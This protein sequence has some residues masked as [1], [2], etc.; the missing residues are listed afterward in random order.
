MS[1]PAAEAA[2]AARYLAREVQLGPF[3]EGFARLIVILLSRLHGRRELAQ[4]KLPP[5]DLDLNMT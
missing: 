5:V 3:A 1:V 4:V 2:A